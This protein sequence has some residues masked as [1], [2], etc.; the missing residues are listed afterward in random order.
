[1]RDV[2]LLLNEM[3]QAGVTLDHALFGAAAQMRYTEPVATL[4]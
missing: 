2:T 3:R 4:P 1:M